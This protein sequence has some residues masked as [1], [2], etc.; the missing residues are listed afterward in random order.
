VWDGADRFDI[1]RP[2]ASH[3][4]FGTGIHVCVG[5]AL[6][7]MET[8]IALQETLEDLAGTPNSIDEEL[9]AA[10]QPAALLSLA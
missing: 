6:A 9:L 5:A 7:R 10:G 8:R 3:L 2:L 4:S 1:T